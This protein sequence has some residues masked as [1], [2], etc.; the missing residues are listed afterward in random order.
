MRRP[1]LPFAV[2]IA[3]TGL[4]VCHA[5]LSDPLVRYFAPDEIELAGMIPHASQD[6]YFDAD[7]LSLATQS[8]PLGFVCVEADHLPIML[9]AGDTFLGRVFPNSSTYFEISAGDHTLIGY[10]IDGKCLWEEIIA[11]PF[12]EITYVASG[13]HVDSVLP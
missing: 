13:E 5:Q 2:L 8:S 9:Y 11:V 6:A 1:L 10:D 12:A 7:L 3:F 4:T